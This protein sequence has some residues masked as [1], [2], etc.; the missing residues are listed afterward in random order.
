MST[1]EPSPIES[2]FTQALDVPVDERAAFLNTHCEDE[3]R[4]AEVMSLLRAYDEAGPFFNDLRA[5]VSAPTLGG[6]YPSDPQRAGT[7][8]GAPDPLGMEGRQ[9]GGYAVQEHV[10]AGGMGLVYRAWD[11]TLERSVALKFLSPVLSAVAE[12]KER[13]VREAR[14]AARVEHPNVAT[15]HEIGE[16]EEGLRFIAMTHYDGDTLRTRM[17]RDGPFEAALVVEYARTIAEALYEVHRV[18]IVH[19]DVKPANVMWTEQGTM[20]LLD[21]GLAK[22]VATGLSRSDRRLGTPSYMSPEQA[23]GAETG[24]RTDVWALGVIMYEMLTGERPFSGEQPQEVLE[25]IRQE[26]PPIHVVQPGAPSALKSILSKCLAKD[27]MERYASARA[28]VEDLDALGTELKGEDA[29]AI[30]VLPFVAR[31]SQET[32]ALTGGMHESVLARLSNVADLKVTVGTAADRADDKT[33]AAVAEELGVRWI[34]RGSVW[35]ANDRIQ[36]SVRLVD[37]KADATAWAETYR[38]DLTAENLFDV[39]EQITQEIAEAL[40]AEVT[41]SE[42]ERITDTPTRNLE[43]YQ[44]YLQ[45]RARLN[46]RKED[47]IIDAVDYFRRAVEEDDTYALAWSGLADAVN[48]FPLFV[49]DDHDPP[50]IDPD[51]AARR[52]LELAPDLAEARASLGYVQG[53]EKGVRHLRRAVELKPSYAQAHQWLALKLLVAGEMGQA[54]EHASIAAELAP[55]N[56]AAQGFLA[57]QRIAAGQYQDGIAI[58]DQYQESAQVE[59]EW[60]LEITSRFLF[61]ALYS[62]GQW[63]NAQGL[64]RQREQ[65]TS[66]PRWRAKWTAKRGMVEV[67]LGESDQAHD[68]LRQLRDGPDALSRGVLLVALGKE[69]A[70][71]AAFTD[72]ETWGHYDIIEFRHFY[73]DLMDS[74]REGPRYVSLLDTVKERRAPSPTAAYLTDAD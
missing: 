11:P 63:E 9:I 44:L 25:A 14:A 50:G 24:P 43:A 73:P 4:R 15:I 59:A 23:E 53:V 52:A 10:G 26:D 27:P 62:L 60:G 3:A 46:E 21:F 22:A 48:L 6:E 66:K 7:D 32:G 42:K 1:T 56:R 70:A 12:V 49:S 28:L 5:T 71:Y 65:G 64:A 61:A 38:R 8:W 34:L 51:H 68:R 35:R 58:I 13:F 30:A 37:A 16:T 45:G 29:R 33:L 55:R 20:K 31:G 36:I 47:G 57:F 67:A 18:G 72:V 69:D 40:T 41:A 17:A 74:F 39:Q 54:H 19:R 2:L